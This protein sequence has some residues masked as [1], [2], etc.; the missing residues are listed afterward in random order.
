M[1]IRQGLDTDVDEKHPTNHTSSDLLNHVNKDLQDISSPETGEICSDNDDLESISDDKNDIDQVYDDNDTSCTY[2]KMSEFSQNDKIIET[3]SGLL[4][5]VNQKHKY[6]KSKHKK[7][8]NSVKK[9]KSKKEKRRHENEMITESSKTF[10]TGSSPEAWTDEMKISH[11][12]H[13]SKKSEKKKKKKKNKDRNP[14]R[15]C[16]PEYLNCERLVNE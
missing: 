13:K 14:S 5:P 8:H 4:S 9:R 7:K 3:D 16:P 2:S 15:V 12:K 1:K 10:E 11:V 6:S